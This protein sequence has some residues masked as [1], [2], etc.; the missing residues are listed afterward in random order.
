MIRIFLFTL[1]MIAATFGSPPSQAWATTV[2]DFETLGATLANDSAYVG[3]DGA[4]GFSEK[5]AQFS[6]THGFGFWLDGHA[7][8][9]RTSFSSGNFAEFADNNETGVAPGEG[10]GGSATWGVVSSFSPD[11]A[12]IEAPN[13]A[14]FDSFYVTNT[15]TTKFII[16]NG[17]GFADPFGGVS[18]NE[19]DLF[20]MRINDLTPGGGGSVE[21]ILADYRSADKFVLDTWQLVDLTSLNKAKKIGFEFT[22]TDFDANGLL[23]PTYAG[24]DDIA[25]TAVPEPGAF[26]GLALLTGCLF[27]WR[28]RALRRPD[29]V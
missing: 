22:S 11:S 12:V 10:V 2:V 7:Y 5:G 17:N 15:T 25:F 26:G 27:W 8:S 4:G 3:A 29:V 1:L 21:V 6:N 20:T 24:I 28:R 23:T 14:Y 9:N 16:E 13:G 18:G 19:P